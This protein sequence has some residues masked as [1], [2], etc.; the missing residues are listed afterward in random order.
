MIGITRA[1]DIE[2][3]Y[4]TVGCSIAYTFDDVLYGNLS[5][6]NKY[7]IGMKNLANT[8]GDLKT[9]INGVKT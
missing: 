4:K 8:L 2:T 9:N 5:S 7:F 3:S 1:S 6:T